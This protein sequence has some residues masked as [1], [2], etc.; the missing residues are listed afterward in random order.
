MSA[1]LQFRH[2]LCRQTRRTCPLSQKRISDWI[3]LGRHRP[4]TRSPD[5][6]VPWEL[7]LQLARA[8]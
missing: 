3:I 5:E 1:Q 8:F 7:R 4:R 6:L 2:G